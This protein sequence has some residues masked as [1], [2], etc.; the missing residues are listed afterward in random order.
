MS[1]QQKNGVWYAVIMYMDGSKKRYKWV[2][3]ASEKDA[4]K[5][6]RSLRTDLSRGE[7]TF[8]RKT[9]FKT[10]SEEWLNLK[11]RGKKRPSTAENYA[12]HMKAICR[13]IGSI[14]L[15]KLTAKHIEEH[16]LGEKKRGLSD[17]SIECQHATLRQA[18]AAAVSWR[19]ISKNPAAEILDPPKRNKPKNAAYNPQQVQ[20]LLDEAHDTEMYI[21]AALGFLVG[22]R[23]GEICAL[24]FQD[25]DLESKSACIRHS[26]DRMKKADA[27]KLFDEGKITWFGRAS[28][29][30]DSVLVLGPLKTDSSEGYVPLPDIVVNAI[31]EEQKAKKRQKLKFGVSYKDNDFLW[32]TDD[33]NPQDPDHLYHGFK[34]L[35]SNYNAKIAADKELTEEQKAELALPMIRPHDMRHTHATLLLR[36]KIDIKIVS[37]KIRHKRASFTADYYQHVSNDMQNETATAMD[38][39]FTAG[40]AK[41]PAKSS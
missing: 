2:K 39:L 20:F 14:E 23:R 26:L 16:Y 40:K 34:L 13:S 30:G 11:I 41:K 33:G 6:E 32:T 12:Q 35:I 1:I 29:K 37:K 15:S 28:K 4:A 27:E 7:V 18:L 22:L 10:F 25:I 17:T 3:A 19:L 8:G 9:D 38:A 5:L 36:S 21:P 31:K 24:R